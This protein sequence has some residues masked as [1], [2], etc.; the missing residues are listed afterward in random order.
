[1]EINLKRIKRIKILDKIMLNIFR[2]TTFIAALMI[3]LVVVV[4][5]QKGISPFIADYDGITVNFFD[6]MSGMSWS[7]PN[8]GVLFIIINTVILALLSALLAIP[9]SV[10]TALFITRLAPKKLSGVFQT[11]IEMLASIPSIVYGVF[12]SIVIT[13]VVKQLAYSIG[14]NTYGGSGLLSAVLVLTIMTIPTITTVS[15]T[16][17]KSVDKK[18]IEGSLALGA[19]NMQTNIKIVLVSAK[20]GI[21]AGAILGIGR[22]LG[23][24]TAVSMVAGN[25]TNGI[26]LGAFDLTRTLTSTMLSGIKETSGLDYDIR[27]SVGLVLIVVILI[28]NAI[29]NLVKNKIGGDFGA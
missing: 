10:L 6:F 20:S 19:S 14:A 2:M 16:A 23:E 18:I 28:T 11:I 26:A 13:Q 7:A 4:I 27:F 9:I 29:L 3:V 25:T 1:M 15:I 12:G 22:A 21:F 17:I 24:A 8:Y 5:A